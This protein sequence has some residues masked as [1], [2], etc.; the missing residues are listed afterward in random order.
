MIWNFSSRVESTEVVGVGSEAGC[1][2]GAEEGISTCESIILSQRN[3]T[4][5]E[6][7]YGMDHVHST[8][9]SNSRVQYVTA[10]HVILWATGAFKNN[11]GVPFGLAFLAVN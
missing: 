3:A 1:V 7:Y 4:Q 5:T 11:Q 10:H 9:S 8:Q 6:Q 2:Q